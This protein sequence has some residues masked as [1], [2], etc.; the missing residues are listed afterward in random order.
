MKKKDKYSVLIVILLAMILSLVMGDLLL[1]AETAGAPQ[2]AVA[3][4]DKEKENDKTRA[5]L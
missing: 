5:V 1:L 2:T 3:P 4:A